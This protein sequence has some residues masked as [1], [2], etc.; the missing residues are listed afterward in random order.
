MGNRDSW[1]LASTFWAGCMLL[2]PAPVRAGSIQLPSD[3]MR[4]TQT[5]ECDAVKRR[6]ADLARQFAERAEQV[7]SDANREERKVPS[8]YIPTRRWQAEYDRA[9]LLH[10]QSLEISRLGAAA[11]QH[12][13]EAVLGV[14]RQQQS[15]RGRQR[16]RGDAYPPRLDQAAPS[17]EAP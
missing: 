10:D 4:D 15:T 11:F 5:G 3:P 13:S 6:Y 17:P 14:Q 7:A 2:G 12:C 1:F 9:L 16:P 8:Q